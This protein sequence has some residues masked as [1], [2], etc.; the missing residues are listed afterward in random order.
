MGLQMRGVVAELW[1][2]YQ[3]VAT[4]R[5]WTMREDGGRLQVTAVIDRVDGAHRLQQQGLS[6][7]VKR[8]RGPAWRWRVVSLQVAD[9][10]VTAT[11]S[12]QE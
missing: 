2:V 10:Q 6:F 1:W 11:L 9:R 8:Q 3:P 4:L 7:V 5:D 12:P